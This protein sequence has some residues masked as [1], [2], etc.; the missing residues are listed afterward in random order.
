MGLVVYR[1]ALILL[2]LLMLPRVA[3]PVFFLAL[4]VSKLL[5]NAL[6]VNL[7]S[8]CFQSTI[9]VWRTAQ[10]EVSTILQAKNVMTAV[11]L[12]PYVKIAYLTVLHVSL[13]IFY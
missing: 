3:R 6:H 1:Y 12:V 5:P 10:M 8:F 13:H 7:D 9:V 11:L 4:I 2:L